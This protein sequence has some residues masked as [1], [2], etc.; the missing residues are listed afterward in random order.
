MLS[1]AK[2]NYSCNFHTLDCLIVENSCSKKTI[3]I[4][5][6]SIHCLF[7]S[8]LLSIHPLFVL[9][10]SIRG[11]TKLED[12]ADLFVRAANQFKVAKSFE[13]KYKFPPL[14]HPPPPSPTPSSPLPIPS[15]LYY[16]ALLCL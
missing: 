3:S 1:L 13:S 8:L 2:K 15:F 4:N 10:P 11:T 9:L 14:S 6:Q 5:C 7:C 16:V 12:A